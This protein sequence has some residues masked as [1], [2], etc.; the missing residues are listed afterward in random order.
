[1]SNAA[2]D[3][4]SAVELLEDDDLNNARTRIVK[5]D[6]EFAAERR[7]ERSNAQEERREN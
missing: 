2:F 5:A 3:Y 7:R 1:M 6:A 4:R